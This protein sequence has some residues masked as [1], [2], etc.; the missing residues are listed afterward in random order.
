[1]SQADILVARLSLYT[2][3][4]RPLLFSLEAERAHNLTIAAVARP[5]VARTLAL[6]P[7]SPADSRLRQHIF[8]LSFAHPIGLAAGLDKQGTAAAAWRAIGFSF[9]EIGTVTPRPQPGNPRPRLFRLPHDRAI[10]NRFGFN[11]EGAAAV[12][13]NL[14]GA[15]GSGPAPTGADVARVGINI[16]R[17]KET[18]NERAVDDYVATIEHLHPLADYFVVNVSSPNTAGLRD[19]QESRT[20]R[21]L[22]A[23]VRSRIGELS[24]AR[25]IP[26]LVKVSPDMAASDL[27]ASV[28]AAVEGGVAGVIATNT[29]VSRPG[30]R[31]AAAIA[32]ET[33]GL[34]GEPLR[35]PANTA[36]AHLFRHLR[37]S[38][39]IVGVGGVFTPD[40][41]YARIRAGASLVQLYTA[42]VYEG[43]GVVGRIVDGL[44]ERLAR[45]GFTNVE[46][47]I[48]IDV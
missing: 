9:A 45:D 20:L 21:T 35:A 48:G 2:R 46:D 14:A 24:P 41:A 12:A 29:T 27:L 15:G 5:I 6:R 16:G 26:L 34:S 39:P 25:A 33:G 11:S 17:N 47:A 4:A 23:A 30:L 43:P 8:G 32:A 28:D 22:I 36:C 31:T 42:L 3:I 40:D 38:V 19:L 1:M 7:H 37:R 18:P 13:R 10:I 44:A